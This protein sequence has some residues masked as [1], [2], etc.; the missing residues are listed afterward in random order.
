[1]DKDILWIL[2]QLSEQEISAISADRILRALELLRKR[3]QSETTGSLVFQE[4][5]AAAE[6]SQAVQ[7]TI[8]VPEDLSSVEN[9]EL[10]ILTKE[11]A[12]EAV[13]K[14]PQEFRPAAEQEIANTGWMSEDHNSGI[15]EDMPQ[16]MEL[17]LEEIGDSTVRSWYQIHASTTSQ[18]PQYG[19]VE[20]TLLPGLQDMKGQLQVR[21]PRYLADKLLEGSKEIQGEYRLVTAMF[22]NL[23]GALEILPGMSLDQYVDDVNDCFKMMVD[24]IYIKYEGCVSYIANDSLLALFGAPIVHENDAERA[25]SSA[26]D[27]R[28]GMEKLDLDVSIGINTGTLYMGKMDSDFC[29]ECSSWSPGIDLANMIKDVASVGE[30]WVGAAAYRLTSR[31]FDFEEAVS[32]KSSGVQGQQIAYPVLSTSYRPEILREIDDLDIGVMDGKR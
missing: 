25:I 3:E 8:A 31:A 6:T 4:Q 12:E 11:V 27:I 22:V 18:C 23:A 5:K 13:E 24:V 7:E 16:D 14:G 10:A 28:N 15:I 21:L 9:A 32:L 26:L 29:I 20:P 17:D 1:M 19:I 2:N 30:I